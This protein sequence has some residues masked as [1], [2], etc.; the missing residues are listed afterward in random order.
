MAYENGLGRFQVNI[1]KNRHTAGMQNTLARTGAY[2]RGMRSALNGM[3]DD[4]TDT[5][6]SSGSETLTDWTK[7]IAT[8]GMTAIG[9]ENAY[10]GVNT[11]KTTGTPASSSNAM[12]YWIGG[13]VLAAA[14]AFWY[15]KKR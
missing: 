10:K 6:D 15:I 1:G 13:G 5:T 9:L 2:Y 8:A 12:Y 3:G 7:S 4:T 11:P 14:A